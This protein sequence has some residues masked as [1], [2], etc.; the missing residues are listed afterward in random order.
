[1][2]S[3]RDVPSRE[4]DCIYRSGGRYD[5]LFPRADRD[6]AFWIAQAGQY[7]DPVLELACGTGRLAIPVAERGFRVTGI[8]YSKAMLKEARQKSAALGVQVE[9]IEADMRAFDLGET[10]TL[11]TLPANA[12]GH[13]LTL[14]DFEACLGSVRKHLAPGGRFVI[15]PLLSTFP[16]NV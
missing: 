10:Y 4:I 9:W 16:P 11:I 12:L 8:D 3:S 5:L 2:S 7:G 14:G 1:M 13:L 6:L 15:D